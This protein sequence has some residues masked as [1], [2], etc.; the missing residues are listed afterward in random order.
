MTTTSRPAPEYIDAIDHDAI[1][2]RVAD[3]LDCA[4]VV[5]RDEE[6]V[7]RNEAFIAILDHIDDG[8]GHGVHF[9]ALRR[10]EQLLNA[11]SQPVV[12]ALRTAAESRRLPF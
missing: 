1:A 6:P 11:I 8:R 9:V 2:D 7:D 3:I 5:D 4:D 12:D 10:C